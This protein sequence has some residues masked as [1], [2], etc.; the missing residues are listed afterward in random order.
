MREDLERLQAAG[1]ERPGDPAVLAS[2]FNALLEGFCA[3]WIAEAGEPIGRPLSDNEAIDTLTGLLAHGLTGSRRQPSNRPG[4]PWRPRLV[5]PG[6]RLRRRTAIRLGTVC[7]NASVV[8][9]GAA[10]ASAADQATVFPLRVR[11]CPAPGPAARPG[12]LRVRACPAPGPT[13]RPGLPGARA[14]YA[15]GCTLSWPSPPSSP[16]PSARHKESETSQT[17][18]AL[19][20][21]PLFRAGDNPPALWSSAVAFAKSIL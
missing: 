21:K 1:F 20:S 13:A 16:G 15:S 12:L 19:I 8:A 17:F 7:L 14:C 6:P 18:H 2:A 5:D 3:R 4:A 10:A 11:A 9:H